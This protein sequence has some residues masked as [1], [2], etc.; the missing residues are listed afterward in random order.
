MFELS[1]EHPDLPM[2][3]V[4]A[5]IEAETCKARV[6]EYDD[7]WMAVESD[8]DPHVIGKR[9]AMCH[10][11]DEFLMSCKDLP[12]I[13]ESAKDIELREG[14]FAV[15]V[16]RVSG[17]MPDV[18]PDEVARKLGTVLSKKNPVDLAS[19]DIT[20]RVILGNRFAVGISICEVD[21]SS[22]EK[23]KAQYRPFFSPISLHPRLARA[24]VNLARAR[25]GNT[26]LDPFCGTGGILMEA[27]LMG[28]KPVG[29][30]KD[31]KMVEG[32]VKNL[33]FFEI[34]GAKVIQADVGAVA[35]LLGTVD[36][37]ATDPPYG[38]STHLYGEAV[39]D[40]Y[41]RTFQSAA[42]LLEQGHYM[43]I[44]LPTTDILETATR[45]F[46]LVDK[47]GVRVHKSLT[48]HFFVFKRV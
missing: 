41:A 12:E 19:P 18:R 40:I 37:I 6:P 10:R 11:I 22:M 1:G 27:G 31:L 7:G 46:E 47:I 35:D 8:I 36:A 16:H 28:M 14:S 29:S 2:A 44:S 3:E 43:A 24:L 48:R 5:C 38:R 20:I 33:E 34:W 13:L 42:G 23:R 9:L 15:R 45:D 4:L 17:L 25:A 39:E 21:R 26:V 32:S 30:D